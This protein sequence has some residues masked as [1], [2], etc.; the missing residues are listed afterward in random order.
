M[1]AV[2]SSADRESGHN[3]GGSTQQPRATAQGKRMARG[4]KQPLELPRDCANTKFYSGEAHGELE[5]AEAWWS[6]ESHDGADGAGGAWLDPWV[7]LRQWQRTRLPIVVTYV[8]LARGWVPWTIAME[9]ALLP[10]QWGL[11]AAFTMQSGEIIGWMRDGL[12]CGWF[13][14]DGDPNLRAERASKA[15]G[16]SCMSWTG[17]EA[18]S[19][20]T[21][22]VRGGADQDAQMTRAT[23]GAARTRGCWPMALSWSARSLRYERC[24]PT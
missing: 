21:A 17:M 22:R 23:Y 3:G 10:G 12:V 14:G 2:P 19:C 8:R 6:G 9:S 16:M 1:E 24:G 20:A 15:A 7:S 11:W 5:L 18:W 13:K 4:L